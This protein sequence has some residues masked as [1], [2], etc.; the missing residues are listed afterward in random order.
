V[1][2]INDP[3]QQKV[4]TKKHVRV[5]KPDLTANDFAR[6]LPRKIHQDKER[7]YS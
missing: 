1:E 3:H 5:I 2:D 6:I 7:L 4:P